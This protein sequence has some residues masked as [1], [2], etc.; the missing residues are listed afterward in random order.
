[1]LPIPSPFP[2]RIG[3]SRDKLFT[4]HALQGEL[5]RASVQFTGQLYLYSA[6]VEMTC[7]SGEKDSFSAA[8]KN[9]AR[10]AGQR[11]CEDARLRAFSLGQNTERGR[12]ARQAR[13]AGVPPAMTNAGKMPA[14][15]RGNGLNVARESGSAGVP[16]ATTNAGKMP[17]LPRGSGL[18]VARESG[19]AGVPP[20]RP[21]ARASRP[22]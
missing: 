11:L 20:A 21:G 10:I 14:L 9:C 17:A 6:R 4:P 16:P 1:M 22:L 8:G 13:S 2:G 18:N 15:H 19:S 5:F 12:L 7:F 3:R